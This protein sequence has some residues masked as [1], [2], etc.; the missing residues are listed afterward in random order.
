[1]FADDDLSVMAYGAYRVGHTLR[2]GAL[3][4]H[5]DQQLIEVELKDS[6]QPNNHVIVRLPQ[7]NGK[8][9]VRFIRIELEII[10]ANT[11]HNG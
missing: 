4:I 11:K 8:G 2:C 5:K 9:H 10:N 7:R 1:M 6:T 3:F